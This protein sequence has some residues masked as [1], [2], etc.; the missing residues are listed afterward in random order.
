[1]E[2]ARQKGLELVNNSVRPLE[3]RIVKVGVGA[4]VADG[5]GVDLRD[6]SE[7]FRLMALQ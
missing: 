5:N 4:A 1:M 6:F 7:E 2:I 3:P